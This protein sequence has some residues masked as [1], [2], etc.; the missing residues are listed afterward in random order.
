MFLG[1][2]S[3]WNLNFQNQSKAL[4]LGV[5]KPT[6]RF[7]AQITGYAFLNRQGKQAFVKE[8][9]TNIC[10]KKKSKPVKSLKYM[11]EFFVSVLMTFYY[12]KV[13]GYL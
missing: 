3:K 9:E 1:K 13:A 4:C 8:N 5:S 6:K 2:Y 11:D 7:A 12:L 10:V